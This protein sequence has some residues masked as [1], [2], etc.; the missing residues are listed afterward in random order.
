MRLEQKHR[1]KSYTM[2]AAKGKPDTDKSKGKAR[3]EANRFPPGQRKLASEGADARKSMQ[4]ETHTEEHW[5][6]NAVEAEGL[7]HAHSEAH[8]GAITKPSLR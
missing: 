3:N 6:T 7:P 4:P 1:P 5:L 8:S 2:R